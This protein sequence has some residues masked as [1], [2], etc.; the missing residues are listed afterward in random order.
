VDLREAQLFKTNHGPPL[1]ETGRTT[2]H[3]SNALDD[4]YTLIEAKHGR[5]GAQIAADSHGW[6]LNYV[7]EVSNE[8]GIDCEYRQLPAYEISQ[9]PKGTKEHD[10]EVAELKSEVKLCQELGM[11]VKF[12][13]NHTIK[14]WTG[15]IDQRDAA[16]FA[17][18]A[19]FHPTK[20]VIGVLKHLA[21]QANFQCY[22]HT[23]M[24]SCEESGGVDLPVVGHVGSRRSVTIQ[25][26]D[27]HTIKCTH[28]VQA[29]CVPLQKL[30]VVAEL[31]YLR[32]YAVAIRV[33]KGVVE[34]CL[35]YD[36]ADPY[37]YLRITACDAENDYLVVGGCDHKVG[38]EGGA[39]DRYKELELWTKERFPQATSV[40]YKWSGHIF[41]PVDAMA[42]IGRNQ[43]DTNIWIVTGDSGNGLT[44]GVIAG[45]LIS[46][47]I[48]GKQH[49]WMELYNP[50][51]LKGIAK[52]LPTMVGHDL[53][54]NAQYKRFLQS[55][56]ED[57]GQ[58]L[59]GSGGVLNSVT[60]KPIAV[61]KDEQGALHQFSAL[62]PHMK[63][64]VCWNDGEKSWDCPVHGSRFSPD[65]VQIMGPAKAGLTPVESG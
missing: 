15:A 14:G 58:L 19:T 2:G 23:R 65:G 21:Q 16:V 24:I 61:Y 17:R 4:G 33:P 29:T 38:Q 9:Y 52:S 54:I 37:K 5:K 48:Q 62:C 35:I 11:D 44:H 26:L 3:L 59:K 7:G 28:T 18:Q 63:G 55:D 53:Q 41:E 13:E 8:L 57:V 43:G 20:Y 64:V 56:I 12:V 39:E 50:T 47:G 25:T 34:D 45:K 30:A 32:T 31:E 60:Q 1:G 46:D 10:E 49:E 40:D 6:A 42:F 51:R 27:G 36:E 22:T